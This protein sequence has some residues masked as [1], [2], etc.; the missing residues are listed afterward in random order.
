MGQAVDDVRVGQ[1][2]GS[3]MKSWLIIT[4]VGMV[5]LG[6]FL[7]SLPSCRAPS[8]AQTTGLLPITNSVGSI[9]VELSAQQEL[10]ESQRQ[11]IADLRRQLAE[12]SSRQS[13]YA[14]K[15]DIAATNLAAFNQRLSALEGIATQLQANHALLQGQVTQSVNRIDQSLVALRE[16]AQWPAESR[17]L[18][19]EAKVDD[20]EARLAEKGW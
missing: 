6:I 2:G 10:I 11:S 20:L 16:G 8:P 17:V 3:R 4:L 18:L 5:I 1:I 9:K 12:L 14:T 19:L 7:L 15:D 13:G